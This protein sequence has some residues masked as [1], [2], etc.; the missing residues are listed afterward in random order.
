MVSRNLCH[1]S[2]T[3]YFACWVDSSIVY[4]WMPTVDNLSSS[5]KV[6]PGRQSC[7]NSLKLKRLYCSLQPLKEVYNLE[8]GV[9]KLCV[10]SLRKL[11]FHLTSLDQVVPFRR[12]KQCNFQGNFTDIEILFVHFYTT[13]LNRVHHYS[14]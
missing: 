5:F 13:Q 12:P 3:G 10:F 1:D 14:V 9:E 8:V 2:H 4:L 11:T 6:I 7:L